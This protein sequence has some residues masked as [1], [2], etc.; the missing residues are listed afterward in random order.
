MKITL[1]LYVDLARKK[2]PPKRFYLGL[3]PYRNSHHMILNQTKVA[4]KELVLS[5]IKALPERRHDLYSPFIFHYTIYPGSKRAFDLGNVLPIVG[6]FAE[7]ALI[8]LGVI[9]DDSW[10]VIKEIR[11]SIGE[12]D[13]ENPRAELEILSLSVG[14]NHK[15]ATWKRHIPSEDL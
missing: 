13:K 4:Y 9:S 15:P 8:E 2:G 1:P 3:N 11:Y 12:V 10:K 7:D 14:V 5:A 6:K